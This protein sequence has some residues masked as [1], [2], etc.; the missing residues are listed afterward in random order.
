M[1]LKSHKWICYIACTYAALVVTW[2]GFSGTAH[3]QGETATA[4]AG[5]YAVTLNLPQGNLTVYLPADLAPGDR[6]SGAIT[7]APAGEDRK[8]LA[9]NQ[10]AL[11]G[12][13]LTCAGQQTPATIG[14]ETWTVPSGATSLQFTFTDGSDVVQGQ[15]GVPV[16]PNAPLAPNTFTFPTDA[17][18]GRPARI[19]GSFDGSLENTR[20]QITGQNNLPQDAELLAESPRSL[21]VRTPDHLAGQTV[22]S[23]S[24][25]VQAASGKS[26]I[27]STFI[28]ITR[29]FPERGAQTLATQPAAKQTASL[30]IPS[31][32]TPPPATLPPA[33]PGIQKPVSIA[34]PVVAEAPPGIQYRFYAARKLDLDETTKNLWVDSIQ[35]WADRIREKCGGTPN[36]VALTDQGDD[37]RAL[38]ELKERFTTRTEGWPSWVLGEDNL[39][40]LLNPNTSPK[41]FHLALFK[42]IKAQQGEDLKSVSGHYVSPQHHGPQYQSRRPGRKRPHPSDRPSLRPRSGRRRRHVHLLPTR[43]KPPRCLRQPGRMARYL[44]RENRTTHGEITRLS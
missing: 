11:N 16:Q 19:S 3:G 25:G 10:A 24:E 9:F 36:L 28:D 13:V 40:E 39:K 4:S 20:V 42:D 1:N 7:V 32:I 27:S 21:V 35:W 38:P 30:A 2:I 31:P 15:I 12:Y 26:S 43:R 18:A 33:P 44:V 17:Q 5:L 34:P 6:I 14:W 29:F 23:L 41:N 8:E 22:I 37:R